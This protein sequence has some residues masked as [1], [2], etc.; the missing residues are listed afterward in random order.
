MATMEL[1]VTAVE[2]KQHWGPVLAER[3]RS[4][5]SG[6]EPVP[7]PDDVIIDPVTGEVRI[8]GPVLE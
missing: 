3:A 4:G 6:P 8:D 2:Y 7:H 5:T 1:F